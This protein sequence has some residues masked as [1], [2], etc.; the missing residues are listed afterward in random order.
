[1]MRK[2]PFFAVVPVLFVVGGCASGP[3]GVY[4]SLQRRPIER[5]ASVSPSQPATPEP[6]APVSATLAEAIRALG[7]DADQGEAAFRAALTEG[8]AEVD[9]GR[10]AAVGSEQWAVAQR[11]LSR[12]DTARAPTTLALAELDR[13]VVTQPDS[14][15]LSAQQLRVATLVATQAAIVRA[16]AD[17][18]AE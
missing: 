17:G 14:P 5:T 12:I 9:A 4:P 3:A 7:A 6:P 2:S 10:G 18:L 8:R 11:A 16:M 15:D 13:L 1:M